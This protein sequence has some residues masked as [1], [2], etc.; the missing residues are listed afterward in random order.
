VPR[1]IAAAAVGAAWL[2]LGCGAS[3]AQQPQTTLTE[4]NVTAP[5]NLQPPEWYTPRPGMIGKV[6]VEED[7]WPIVPCATS[8]LDD[9]SAPGTC[10]EGPKGDEFPVVWWSRLSAAG[11]Q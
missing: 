1:R 10:Q 11:F 2:T 6:R 9:P 4:L 3:P 8:R 5:K 7:K